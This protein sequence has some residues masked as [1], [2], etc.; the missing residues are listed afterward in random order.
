MFTVSGTN[1]IRSVTSPIQWCP[2]Q[3]TEWLN[4]PALPPH[5]RVQELAFPGDWCMPAPL[6][7]NHRPCLLFACCYTSLAGSDPL[8]NRSIHVRSNI[9]VW[10]TWII[11]MIFCLQS[12]KLCLT[13]NF[14]WFVSVDFYLDWSKHAALG[15]SWYSYVSTEWKYTKMFNLPISVHKLPQIYVMYWYNAHFAHF[16]WSMLD[17]E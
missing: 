1:K 15:F 3:I 14:F 12:W 4:S 2:L 5:T 16:S 13:P 10:Y 11:M 9:Y 17:P 8:K 6:E 7:S